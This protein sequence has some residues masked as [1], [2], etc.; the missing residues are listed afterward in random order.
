MIFGI[1]LQTVECQLSKNL[2]AC[3]GMGIR[4]CYIATKQKIFTLF[5]NKTKHNW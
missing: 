1:S 2:W 4:F 3:Y 5:G